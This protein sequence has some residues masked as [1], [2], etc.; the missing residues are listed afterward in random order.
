[1][2]CLTSQLA[3]P[4]LFPHPPRSP[5]L[6]PTWLMEDNSAVRIASFKSL[7]FSVPSWRNR[8][9]GLE[10]WWDWGK[11]RT[12]LSLHRASLNGTADAYWGLTVCGLVL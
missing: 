5:C 10:L 4:W 7:T 9:P 2:S 8:G 3:H 12:W 6:P 1:M 11:S